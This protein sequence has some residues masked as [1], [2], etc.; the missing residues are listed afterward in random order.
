MKTKSKNPAQNYDS[1]L[2][3]S[4]SL[5][6]KLCFCVFCFFVLT[7]CFL[8]SDAGA[9]TPAEQLDPTSFLTSYLAKA[10]QDV[11]APNLLTQAVKPQPARQ[12]LSKATAHMMWEVSNT[13]TAYFAAQVDQNLPQSTF[14]IAENPNSHVDPN[15]NKERLT[16]TSFRDVTQNET[17][18]SLTHQL[19]QAWISLPKN[20]EDKKNKDELQQII[21][22]IYSIEFKPQNKTPEP[23]IVV[24]Q[25]S[26]NEPNETLA[27]TPSPKEPKEKEIKPNLP[28]QPVSEQTLQI[29]KN[30]LQH[31]DQLENP[32][33]LGEVLFLSGRLKEAAIAYKEALNRKRPDKPRLVE[34]RAW[35]LFQIGNCLRDDDLPTATETYRKLITEYPDSP[36]SDLAKAQYKLIDWYQKNKPRTLIAES[37]FS[38]S[39]N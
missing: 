23:V 1:K 33:E 31:P 21:K 11:N 32:S 7:F 9:E 24:E 8:T 36:W 25:T 2:K 10:S 13:A 38:D 20:E 15:H 22:Q 3:T 17:Q 19:W 28:Y 34:D 30:L 16:G 39:S 14:S 37:A 6:F 18:T 26:T 29:L 27:D 12:E 4:S 35:I 5:S